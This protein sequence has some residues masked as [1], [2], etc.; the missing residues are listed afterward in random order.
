M[1]AML[2][3]T[4]AV[5]ASRLMHCLLSHLL[6]CKPFSHAVLTVTHVKCKDS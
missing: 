4:P 1:H 6:P 3:V 2:I 5:L